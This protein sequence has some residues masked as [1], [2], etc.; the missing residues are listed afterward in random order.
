MNRYESTYAPCRQSV[1]SP[2][3]RRLLR[4]AVSLVLLG[5]LA[6]CLIGCA[7]NPVGPDAP[8]IRIFSASAPVFHEATPTTT[9]GWTA[10]MYWDTFNAQTCTLSPGVGLVPCSGSR[11]I[12]PP[13]TGR[14]VYTL[15]L[16]GRGGS[17]DFTLSVFAPVGV[18]R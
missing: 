12:V 17:S 10:E 4:V 15:H 16:E 14:V 13:D 6:L 3:E 8:T 11:Q 5:A 18:G 9:A 1:A 2:A 7:G